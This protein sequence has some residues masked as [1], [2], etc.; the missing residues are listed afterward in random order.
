MKKYISTVRQS[1][2][3]K[4]FALAGFLLSILGCLFVFTP[5]MAQADPYTL[6]LTV[7]NLDG[8]PVVAAVNGQTVVLGWYIA[9]PLSNCRIEQNNSVTGLTTIETI[10]APLPTSGNKEVTPPPDSTTTFI[11]NCDEEVE[12]TPLNYDLPEV[13]LTS[14][15][16]VNLVNSS[17]T[18]RVDYLIVRWSSVNANRC[19]YVT[20]EGVSGTFNTETNTTDYSNRRG[21]SGWIRYDGEPRFINET[22]TFYITCYNDTIGAEET[23]SLT[24]NVENPPPPGDPWINMTSPD[25][26]DVV[27]SELYGYAWVDVGFNSGNVTWCTQRARYADGTIYPNPPNWGAGST[28]FSRNFT[29]IQLATTTIFEIQCGRGAVTI[30][31]VMYPA[32]ST[33]RQIP[34]N[35]LMPGGVGDDASW[36]RT[37]L[38][39]VT[40]SIAVTPNPA[41]KNM[42]S[43][44][45]SIEVVVNRQNA[46]R[47]YLRSYQFNDV[48]GE[49]SSSYILSGWTRVS[50]PLY[51]NGTTTFTITEINRDSRLSVECI[52]DYDDAYGTAEEMANG[53]AF[54]E[55]IVILE[56]D[57]VAPPDPVV[58]LYGSAVNMGAALMWSSATEII[59][60]NQLIT[61]SPAYIQNTS[62][63]AT[64]NRISFPF[65]H[66]Y[67]GTDEF[68]IQLRTCD[69]NDGESTFRVYVEGSL[70]GQYTTDSTESLSH[71]CSETVFRERIAQGVTISHN[72]VV[73]VECDTPADGERC[74]LH[75]VYFGVPAMT[76]TPQVNPIVESVPVPL[77]WLS[78]NTSSCSDFI[79]T[80]AD[81]STY[82]W[83][84][85]SGQTGVVTP[86]VSTSTSFSITCGREADM[87]TDSAVMGAYVPFSTTLTA[88]ATI[89]TGE[90]ID[91]DTLL[92]IDAPPGYGPDSDGYCSPLVDLA[93]LSPDLSYTGA[94][95]NNIDG[96]YENLRSLIVIENHGPGGLPVASSIS[97]LARMVI[98]LVHGLPEATTNIGYFNDVLLAPSDPLVPTQSDTLDRTFAGAIPFG[99]HL[100]CSR[101]NLD[102]SPNFPEIDGGLDN[103]ENCSTVTVPVPEP[104]MTFTADKY[105]VRQGQPTIITWG[106]NVTYEL[107]CS[108][109]GA[110]GL[111]ESFNTSVV[112]PA[113]IDTTTVSLSNT[114]LFKLEC[115]EPITNTTFTEEMRVEVVPDYMEI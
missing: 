75:S 45:A 38:P 105:Y 114:G 43:G 22:T 55:E 78:K 46:S 111:D 23:T 65:V 79:A 42:L 70:V 91:P 57:P 95:I 113:Y 16:G 29:D 37:M 83:H 66:P 103:N 35:V 59:G 3:W 10:T 6:V 69:E 100:L 98:M 87:L 7:Q 68:D 18:G 99:T 11:I 60:F 112:G 47:C 5:A 33:T 58:Y 51:G 102:G 24:V 89:G 1:T 17:L 40:A 74:R 93:A 26:P 90:C 108:V 15:Q 82:E 53:R 54:V 34:I 88:E 73:T 109:R 94:T 64:S 49:Y 28:V 27:R 86:S 32:T 9:G 30:S 56:A 50:S 48:T 115:T 13:T 25:Y 12:E 52:R 20:R 97:Y 14:D 104:P 85:G 80:R 110:G 36:D 81:G 61:T 77:L 106:V 72:D 101:V 71:L 96:T 41:L 19:S 84:T 39:P 107:E 8:T 76:I 21:T 67:E 4:Q 92:Q 44:K 31:G 63:E 2:F 62:A